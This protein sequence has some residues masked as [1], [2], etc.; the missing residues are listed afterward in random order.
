[1]DF[2]YLRRLRISL[3]LN[4][5]LCAICNYLYNLKTVKNTLGVAL[6]LV[7]LGASS[8]NCTKINTPPWVFFTFYHIAQSIT[9]VD[10][11][12]T[13]EC[14][15]TRYEMLGLINESALKS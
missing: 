12:P 4:K 14:K 11:I 8:C 10:A 13:M 9:I 2:L 15:K 1:M 6:T 3:D 7:K 5:T